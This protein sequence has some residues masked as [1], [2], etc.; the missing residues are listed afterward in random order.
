MAVAERIVGSMLREALDQSDKPVKEVAMD[1]NYSPDAFYATMTGKRKI[2][3]DARQQISEIHPLAGMAAAH[4]ATGY[5][6][7]LVVG[8]DLH[9]QNV[10]QKVLKEDAEV[11]QAL[12]GMG[13][14]IIDKEGPEDLNEDDRAAI[15]AATKELIDRINA[16]FRL[17]IAW[18]NQFKLELVKMFY[19]ALTEKEKRPHKAA[20][21]I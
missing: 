13:F 5:R 14:R 18:E 11:D 1:T 17:I 21:R 20:T 8:G 6:C 7:F 10:L 16:D 3:R 15:R 19:Q 4:E 9:P 2:P 12:A